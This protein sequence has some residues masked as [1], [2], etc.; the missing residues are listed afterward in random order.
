MKHPRTSYN[1]ACAHNWNASTNTC[2]NQK[3]LKDQNMQTKIK[4][5]Y[6][7]QTF[8]PKNYTSHT[9]RIGSKFRRVFNGPVPYDVLDLKMG[10]RPQEPAIIKS[11]TAE[12]VREETELNFQGVNRTALQAY[13]KYKA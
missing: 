4:V 2:L 13:I 11:L 7:R 10:I 3:G 9:T 12:R 6:V 1:Q 5:A 8:H